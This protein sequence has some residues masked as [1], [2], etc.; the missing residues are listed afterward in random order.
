MVEAW[1][2]LFPIDLT[3]PM[4]FPVFLTKEEEREERRFRRKLIRDK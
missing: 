3:N 2:I 1:L 4:I